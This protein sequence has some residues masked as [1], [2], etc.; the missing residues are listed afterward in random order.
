V[1][2]KHVFMFCLEDRGGLRLF[3]HYATGLGLKLGL[4]HLRDLSDIIMDTKSKQIILII[5]WTLLQASTKLADWRFVIPYLLGLRSSVGRLP[6][7]LCRR[8]TALAGTY[9]STVG[10]S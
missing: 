9:T 2:V 7:C 3:P 6:S 5:S 8:N 1:Q 10:S 4:V